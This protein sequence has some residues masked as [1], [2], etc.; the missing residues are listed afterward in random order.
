MNCPHCDGKCR[1]ASESKSLGC[2][3]LV[4]VLGAVG[5][6]VLE[7]LAKCNGNCAINKVE[8]YG[9]SAQST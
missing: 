4:V 3:C 6:F 1:K 9:Y 8:N 2:G 5:W 7:A